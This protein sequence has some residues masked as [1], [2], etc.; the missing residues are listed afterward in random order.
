MLGASLCMLVLVGA[1][2]AFGSWPGAE[3]HSNVDQVLLRDVVQPKPKTVAVRADAVIV[4]KRVAAQRRTFAQVTSPGTPV[5]VAPT[6]SLPG[7]PAPTPS[8]PSAGQAPAAQ[9]QA[10]AR[11]VDTTTRGVTNQVQQQVTN[12]Q[13]QVN[14]VVGE[15]IGGP[16]P[17]SDPG[18]VETVETTVGS[19]LGG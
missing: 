5:A 8:A 7:A 12:V 11:N 3:A 18:P 6:T 19:L 4:A 15:I 14:E 17:S 2:V 13:T 1:F 16:Q 9:P 10:V